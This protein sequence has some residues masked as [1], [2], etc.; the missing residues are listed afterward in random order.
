MTDFE[1]DGADIET[2]EAG[3]YTVTVT[4]LSARETDYG[5]YLDFNLE[6]EGSDYEGLKF[7][8]PFRSEIT[9]S[10]MLGQLIEE[11]T[12]TEV[13]AG[14]SYDL[15]EIFVGSDLSVTVK[16]DDDGFPS[17]VK[18]IDDELAISAAE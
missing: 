6:V 10:S 1:V 9:P 15:E 17:V 7:G 4:E 11:L 18:T 3:D 8:V 2:L 13:T 14:E 5:P 16:Q 12:G